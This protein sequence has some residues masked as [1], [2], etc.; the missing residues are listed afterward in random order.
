MSLLLDALKKTGQ[1][2]QDGTRGD[3]SNLGAPDAARAAGQNL[4]A[5]KSAS[6]PHARIGIVPLALIV[7]ILLAALGGYY[8]WQ[9][10]SHSIPP[11]AQVATSVTQPVQRSE[12]A[13]IDQVSTPRMQP[14]ASLPAATTDAI[15]PGKKAANVASAAATK[16]ASPTRR[17]APLPAPISIERSQTQD[18]IGSLLIAAYQDYRT[19]DYPAALQRYR[20]V[21]QQD[22]RNRDA[23]LGLAA[24]AR[25]QDQDA[26]AAEYYG[27][28][29]ALDPRDPAA[30]AGM[31]ALTQG[32]P[33]ATES[34][35]KLL[36]AQRP[37]AAELYFVLGNLYA[38]QSRWSEAQQSYFS[39]VN[40]D[41][42]MAQ[43]LFN[44]AVSLDHLGQRKLAVQ[45][46]QQ[47][48]LQDQEGTESFDH[49]Q[50]RQR[51]NELMVP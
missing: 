51:L 49:A 26:T 35:L 10:T 13:E 43:Y 3:A 11:Q 42:D 29:L 14:V 21:L 27:Q 15:T 31:S 12:A 9:E 38:G 23:L 41:P 4:F 47:A 36:L 24:I 45:Y 1:A 5:A 20:S 32:D 37:D 44:L 48:L 6:R 46:Y 16:P 39:A 34:R 8:V 19:G 7:G 33:A 40:R 28:V 18:T 22:A 30:H 50:T 17:T 25:Q 2:R